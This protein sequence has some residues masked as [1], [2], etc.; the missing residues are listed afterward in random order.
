L[1]VLFLSVI[2][3]AV[4]FHR[5]PGQ[6]AYHF[7]DTSPDRWAGRGAITIWLLVPQGLFALLAFITVRI[8][9]IGANYWSAENAV[10]KRV[11]PI[12]GNIL[13]L[14]QLILLFA[15]LNIFL[16]NI[17]QTRPINVWLVSLAVLIL[18]AIAL[19]AF[20]II[21]IRNFRR[22]YGKKPGVN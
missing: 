17:Y 8:I 14:P 18:G 1:V 13:A 3:V 11:L 9:L 15:M 10:L 2:M 4:F 5:L 16:Y 7:Q 6:V 12:M 19:V 21:T 22:R 20:F